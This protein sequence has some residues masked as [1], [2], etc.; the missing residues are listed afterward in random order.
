MEKT[1]TQTKFTITI[2][3][4]LEDLKYA[5]KKYFGNKQKPK[6]KDISDWLSN[7]AKADV[8]CYMLHPKNKI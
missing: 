1:F 3:Y 4:S 8:Q 7:L 5:Y 6:K 2:N